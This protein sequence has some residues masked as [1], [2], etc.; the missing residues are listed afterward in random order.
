MSGAQFLVIKESDIKKVTAFPEFP[1]ELQ[2][3]T[4]SAVNEEDFIKSGKPGFILSSVG[5]DNV[6]IKLLNC[7]ANEMILTFGERKNFTVKEVSYSIEL[8]AIRPNNAVSWNQWI[9]SF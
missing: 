4:A 9:V 8:W 6:T 1:I 2:T 3:L 7:E 5:T